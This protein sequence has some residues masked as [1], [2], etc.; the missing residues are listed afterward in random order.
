MPRL[1][2]NE[3]AFLSLI[4]SLQKGKAKEHVP[5]D[6]SSQPQPF[7]KEYRGFSVAPRV[8]SDIVEETPGPDDRPATMGAQEE[9]TINSPLL[10]P[11]GEEEFIDDAVHA[12]QPSATYT[13]IGSNFAPGTT[14]ADIQVAILSAGGQVRDCWIVSQVP[15]VTAEMSFTERAQADHV[16][17]AFDN[18]KADGHL[19][20][21][22]L[23]AEDT[24][25]RPEASREEVELAQTEEDTLAGAVQP[26]QQLARP[27]LNGRG[28]N[29]YAST[30]GATD[31]R[32]GVELAAT[33]SITKNAESDRT[34][35]KQQT[36]QKYLEEEPELGRLEAE[37]RRQEAEAGER[38]QK[39]KK[40]EAEEMAWVQAA[41]ARYPLEKT[42]G[43]RLT[44]EAEV[45][46]LQTLAEEKLER[47]KEVARSLNGGVKQPVDREPIDP[48]PSTTATANNTTA[49]LPAAMEASIS[50]HLASSEPITIEAAPRPTTVSKSTTPL[51]SNGHEFLQALNKRLL[52]SSVSTNSDGFPQPSLPNEILP[53]ELPTATKTLPILLNGQ[54]RPF[55]PLTQITTTGTLQTPSGEHTVNLA[56]PPP[57]PPTQVTTTPQ[58]TT[59]LTEPKT[60][61]DF[62]SNSQSHYRADSKPP[63]PPQERPISPTK[64]LSLFASDHS[65]LSPRPNHH[66][67]SFSSSPN[68]PANN[69]NKTLT[70]LSGSGPRGYIYMPRRYN[71]EDLIKIEKA[72]WRKAFSAL[73]ER[74]G[75]GK[76]VVAV[77]EGL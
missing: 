8:L 31:A 52:P 54:I 51:L 71:I 74:G 1:G 60:Y 47:H 17:A 7:N 69:N 11:Q 39:R 50:S 20:R 75:R 22:Y 73:L 77:T 56:L 48:E 38:Y 72:Y 30:N 12:D 14:A 59:S 42:R 33:T 63:T 43:R 76:I 44:E 68:P 29:L 2:S 10:V 9:L 35:M 40:A 45:A 15:I 37:Y 55:S 4:K 67:N 49:S 13:V 46:R 27:V 26:Q 36:P 23:K 70:L 21:V 57:P 58:W 19:L 66:I 64:H 24:N 34:A 28:R 65:T 62:N 32:A 18:K 3:E 6:I 25:T 41:A 16:I 53:D 61:F 5:V